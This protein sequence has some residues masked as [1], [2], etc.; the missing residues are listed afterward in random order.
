MY[1][2]IIHNQQY[3]DYEVVNSNSFKVMSDININ[4][5]QEKL[6]N[7]D[8]FDIIDN[9]IICKHSMIRSNKYLAGVLDLSRTHGKV[10]KKFLYKCKP[11][12]KRLPPFII[13]YEKKYSFNKNITKIYITFEFLK[14]DSTA[15]YGQITQIIGPVN[16]L[17]NFYE[18]L[19]YTKSL[20]CS[21]QKF[22][23]D[24]IRQI[25]NRTNEEIIKDMQTS[26]N[27]PTRDKQSYYIFTI[28]NDH[29]NDH[30]DALS[31]NTETQ[32]L[33]IY[34]SNVALIMDHLDL[35]SSFSNRI[36]SIY[37]PD[38]KR[39]MLPSVL[40]ECLC[41]LKEGEHH[42]T[43]VLDIKIINN[44]I[45]SHDLSICNAYISKN[46]TYTDTIIDE[47]KEYSYIKSFFK[48]TRN[49]DTVHKSM[50][51]FNKYIAKVLLENKRGIFK[52][53]VQEKDSTIPTYLPENIQ[54]HIQIL[55]NNSAS[56]AEYSN[57][58]YK[59]L[60]DNSID[61]YLQATS[62]I[63][64]LVDLLNNIQILSIIQK[65]NISDSSKEF[66]N[67]W[68]NRLEYI[69]ISS[70]AI[71]KIQFKCDILVQHEKNKK[72]NPD[73][74]YDGYIF[75]RCEKPND[76]KYQ[77][78]IYIPEIRLTCGV[79]E[80]EYFENYSRQQFKIYVFHDEDTFKKKIKLHIISDS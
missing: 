52:N 9:N 66:Y 11:D 40:S 57:Q 31:W 20:N 30:D 61:V 50:T 42:I 13:P 47:C 26:N 27:I 35:W 6:F 32:T 58:K 12:D 43:Y 53:L 49:S 22:T 2:I 5:L 54:T 76:K 28:D 10:K 72:D 55:R 46:F 38:R 65:N 37:L 75:D 63:R 71:R 29:S 67:N 24:A 3:S 51:Y 74:I 21:I 59:S 16:E 23:K 1:K 34:I 4:P 33:S 62:P 69:N 78:M 18:Y 56:Y 80:S 36:S 70:R 14:W 45:I 39:P 41:S 8:N 48:T 15:P 17:N 25:K 64:R 60:T 77:Y 68:L 7:N 79:T 44:E 73:K 19:L